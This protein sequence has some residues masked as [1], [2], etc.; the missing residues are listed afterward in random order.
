MIYLSRKSL[1]MLCKIRLRKFRFN[2][3]ISIAAHEHIL[4]GSNIGALRKSEN[5]CFNRN[6][7]KWLDADALT[8]PMPLL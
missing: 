1:E 2:E 3:T 7:H 6:Y 5:Q 4:T 8:K